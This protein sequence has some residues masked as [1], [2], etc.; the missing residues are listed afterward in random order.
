MTSGKQPHKLKLIVGLG[1]NWC[2]DGW[3]E[4]M[5]TQSE[6][7]YAMNVSSSTYSIHENV[8]LKSYSFKQKQKYEFE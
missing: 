1:T 7:N 4:A 3:K 8:E 5:I 6:Y 2:S